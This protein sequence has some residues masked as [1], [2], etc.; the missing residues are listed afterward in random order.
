[1]TDPPP[2]LLIV[3][4]QS[5]LHAINNV[6]DKRDQAVLG[7]QGKLPNAAKL[8]R[9]RVLEHT[10]TRQ[11][12]ATLAVGLESECSPSTLPFRGVRMLVEADADGQHTLWLLLQLFQHYL[13]PLLDAGLLGSIH[14]PLAR[15]DSAEGSRYMWNDN[16]KRR[17]LDCEN[18]SETSTI[19]VFKG[20]ASLT[21]T[22]RHHW[23][24]NPATRREQVYNPGHALA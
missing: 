4:G 19:T 16:E 7:L 15:I 21:A 8:S 9:K 18:T 1:M 10:Q 17:Y 11:L 5:A 6:R 13:H 24:I 2:E 22:E 3:E 14:C 20:I 23:L 12:I